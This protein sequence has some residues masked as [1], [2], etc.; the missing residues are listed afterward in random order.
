LLLC[1][2]LAACGESAEDDYG[3]RFPPIDRALVVLGDD[4]ADGLRQADDATLAQRFDGYARRLGRLRTRLDELDPP[5]PLERDHE[6]L[7]GAMTAEREQLAGVAAAA[8]RGD[9]AAAGA[10]ATAVVRE[11]ARLDQAR[12]RLARELGR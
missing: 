10:A 4:V 6:R 1:L 7:L 2:A 11:G 12:A 9:A 3:E 5:G 8:R